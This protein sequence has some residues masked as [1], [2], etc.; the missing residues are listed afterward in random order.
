MPEFTL[1]RASLK[2][3]TS[4]KGLI[5]DRRSFYQE[6]KHVMHQI[7]RRRLLRH[8]PFV[9]K[10]YQRRLG[11]ERAVK[12]PVM[13]R[14][15]Q[16][17]VAK[18]SRKPPRVEAVPLD[19]RD[20]RL[21]NDYGKAMSLLLSSFGMRF[22]YKFL[23]NLFGDGLAVT[24]TQ[25]GPWAGFPLPQD[26]EDL[27][28][29]NARAQQF[30]AENPLPFY[31][32][33]VDP[34]TCYPPIEDYRDDGVFVEHGYRRMSELQYHLNLRFGTSGTLVPNDRVPQGK[35]YDELELPPGSLNMVETSEVWTK[36]DVAIVI[37]GQSDVWL[38][39]NPTGELP[40]AWSWA[41]P[42]GVEDPTNVGMSVAFPLYYIT[43]WIDTMVATM[44]AWSLFAAPTPYTTQDPIQGVRPTQ[45]YRIESYE[46]GMM[47]HFPTGRR[48]GVLSPPDVGA[49]VQGFLNFLVEGAERGG[50][51]GL[52]SGTGIGTR[53]PALTFQAAFEAAIDRLRPAVAQGEEALAA[54]LR[55]C[56]NIVG[57]YDE[58]V[59][60]NGDEYKTDSMEGPKTRRWAK[61]RP[62]EARKGR[63][64]V[65]TLGLDS[66]QDL[67]AK[68]THAVFMKQSGMWSE[69][70]A[71]RFAGVEDTQG[72]GDLIIGDTARRAVLPALIQAAIASDP[73]LAALAQQQAGGTSAGAEGGGGRKQK[74]EPNGPRGGRPKGM[75]TQRPRGRREGPIGKSF[76]RT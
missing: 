2:V 31:V 42:T 51:P 69:D 59:S 75:P 13:Y 9:P 29:Y 74:G 67:I 12:L 10:A 45:E 19:G 21:A 40:Y 4:I 30:L 35:T 60:V 15:I 14:L 48:P 37:Q 3:G 16:E 36:K 65:V 52:V 64:L 47:Y 7:R 61:I 58:N 72:E 11:G 27:G 8:K 50:L 5:Q 41:D 53:L 44:A 76:G 34:L 62:A 55:K 70:R 56:G 46:P 57:M 23:Y 28:V 66:T 20:R 73:D 22:F 39:D 24:K 68:G 54:T 63:R 18:A 26:Q 17:S 43:P 33:T 32:R 25:V 49:Q 6:A 38:F 1:Q 71:M